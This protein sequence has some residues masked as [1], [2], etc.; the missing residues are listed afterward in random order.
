MIY[1]HYCGAD[2]LRLILSQKRLWATHF[3]Y[4][5]DSGEISR[6]IEIARG[7][8]RELEDKAID[9][10]SRQ[11]FESIHIQ[12]SEKFAR[13]IY[14][15]CFSAAAD[16]LSQWRAYADD[17]RGYAIGFDFSKLL[18]R[19]AP[20]GRTVWGQVVYDDAMFI[21]SIRDYVSKH[22]PATGT[23]IET[24]DQA[25]IEANANLISWGLLHAAVMFKHKGFEEEQEVR[26]AFVSNLPSKSD[27]VPVK[28][29]SEIEGP[30]FL[31]SL[32]RLMMICHSYA[33]FE[34]LNGD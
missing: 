7:V 6:G 15:V 19:A 17:G 10:R 31:A 26:I 29:I 20:S 27:E 32:I 24:D 25:F 21:Q 18:E 14:L 33:D 12:L 13:H 28:S 11:F 16:R 34:H 5:N 1:Y 3:G 2:A 4:L 9:S 30:I 8:M 23:A 22:A